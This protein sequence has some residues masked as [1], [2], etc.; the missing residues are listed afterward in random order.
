MTGTTMGGNIRAEE[1][2]HAMVV[3]AADVFDGARRG[4]D[5]VRATRSNNTS[6]Q[7]SEEDT[8]MTADIIEVEGS[9]YLPE[10]AARIKAEHEQCTVALKRGL[11]HAVAAGKLL[12]EAKAQ[13]KHGQWL[14]WLRDQCGIPE[15]TARR[16]MQAA[17]Y[18]AD[19]IGHLA[20]LTADAA[21][22]AV[23]ALE[24]WSADWFRHWL[25]APF[26]EHDAPSAFTEG[27]DSDLWWVRIKLLHQIAAPPV[28]SSMLSRLEKR[29]FCDLPFLRLCGYE[30]LEQAAIALDR[31]AC[32]KQALKVNADTL[33]G[34]QD[35][36]GSIIVE[37]LRLLGHVLGEIERR[38]ARGYTEE[39]YRREW[40]ETHAAWMAKVD[41]L[42]AEIEARRAAAS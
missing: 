27:D 14:R 17:P 40:G 35:T 11:Q 2:R 21:A 20:D 33:K 3:V 42:K 1:E 37:A 31:V 10:L 13:L 19:E 34:L 39:Q 26:T 30:E 41:I 29:E 6:H 16:Y 28:V 9:N 8:E 32:E 7:S 18:A 4:G 23:K 25:D 12:I 38:C 24:P 36:A 22:D 15:R 5:A